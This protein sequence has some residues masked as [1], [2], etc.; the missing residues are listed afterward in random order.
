MS[1]PR[2]ARSEI[3]G[4]PPLGWSGWAGNSGAMASQI[5]SGTS[6][7]AMGGGVGVGFIPE[8]SHPHQPLVKPPSKW[9]CA[10][11][12]LAPKAPRTEGRRQGG[13]AP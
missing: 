6:C 5:W 12:K 13:A 7:S 3:Q 11:L 10:K 9:R 8:A 4:R 1:P 2:T